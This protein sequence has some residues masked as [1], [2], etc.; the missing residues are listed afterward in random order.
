MKVLP[1][2][3]DEAAAHACFVLGVSLRYGPK[4]GSWSQ[5]EFKDGT[6]MA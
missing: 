6:I 2:Q 5:S 1:M 3:T 4:L